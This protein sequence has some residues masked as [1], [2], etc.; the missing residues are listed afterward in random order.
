[1][2]GYTLEDAGMAMMVCKDG[3]EIDAQ[4]VVIL[5]NEPQGKVEELENRLK[6]SRYHTAPNTL[7]VDMEFNGHHITRTAPLRE[8]ESGKIDIVAKSAGLMWR[9]LQEAINS[10]KE[11]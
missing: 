8:I 1:M 2:S 7:R 9:A 10:T 6:E 5:L 4:D 3:N 11:P